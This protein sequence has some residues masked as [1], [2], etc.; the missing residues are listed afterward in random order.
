MMPKYTHIHWCP[1]VR[2]THCK[3]CNIPCH[4]LD[5]DASDTL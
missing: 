3:S 4:W 1:V 2:L 5:H